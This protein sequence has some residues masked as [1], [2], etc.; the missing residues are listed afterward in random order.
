MF[1][2]EKAIMNSSFRRYLKL[3]KERLDTFSI[4]TYFKVKQQL[5]RL[6]YSKIKF[7]FWDVDSNKKRY[8]QIW[9]IIMQGLMGYNQ[10][11]PE[12]KPLPF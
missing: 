10:P 7:A 9:F 2:T 8:W 4:V 1:E 5:I 6:D 11:H 12:Q 3:A